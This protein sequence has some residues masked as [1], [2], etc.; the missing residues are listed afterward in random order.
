MN[1]ECMIIPLFQTAVILC[2]VTVHESMASKGPFT[3]RQFCYCSPNSVLPIDFYVLYNLFYFSY[4]SGSRR[5]Q[6]DFILYLISLQYLH[7]CIDKAYCRY[8]IF[9]YFSFLSVH[10]TV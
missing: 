10:T 8:T 2:T 4:C 5:E 1:S 7:A 9:N 6:L 3:S